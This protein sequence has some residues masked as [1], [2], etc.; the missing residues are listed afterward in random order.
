[1]EKPMS[2]LINGEVV[3][4]YI[5]SLLNARDDGDL[6]NDEVIADI[7][8]TIAAAALGKDNL[9]SHI[10]LPIDIRIQDYQSTR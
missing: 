10:S 5:K 6:T 8:H 4:S 1:M 9:E 2:Y 7:V 3:E